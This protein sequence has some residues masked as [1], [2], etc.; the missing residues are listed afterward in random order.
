MKIR[1]AVLLFAAILLSSCA[2]DSTPA[3]QDSSAVTTQTA[4]FRTPTGTEEDT[5]EKIYY[6]KEENAEL[7]VM[8]VGDEYLTYSRDRTMAGWAPLS[9][10]VP[11][12]IALGDGGFG[13]LTA[14][15][16]RITG[17]GS[18]YSN[19]P[20]TDRLIS[21]RTI[22]FAEAEE[23]AQLQDYYPGDAYCSDPAVCGE[24]CIVYVYPEYH[25]YRDGTAVG[26]YDDA[27][28]AQAA[29]GLSETDGDTDA[30]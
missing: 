4:A 13:I 21:F 17:G 16:T 19:V 28:A 14:D 15:I 11:D 26:T 7:A 20:Q 10:A 24:Y 30:E 2:S 12:G 23:Y 9:G 22:S 27:A 25:I 5:A 18:G 1:I 29:M 8:R 6:N 3:S